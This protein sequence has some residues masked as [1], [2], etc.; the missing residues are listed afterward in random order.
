MT[1]EQLIPQPDEQDT[2]TAT[3]RKLL[4]L[5][6]EAQ[7]TSPNKL[8]EVISS[9]HEIWHLETTERNELLARYGLAPKEPVIEGDTVDAQVI[10]PVAY[11][12]DYDELYNVLDKGG[13]LSAAE[14]RAEIIKRIGP[15]PT[16]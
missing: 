13:R 14:I 3:Y 1:I 11:T 4:V 8:S 9:N 10:T 5:F 16:E 6:D 12:R 7:E 15:E 2:Y